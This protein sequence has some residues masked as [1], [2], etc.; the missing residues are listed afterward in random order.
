MKITNY[1]F[2]GLALSL[3]VG[4][5]AIALHQNNVS[6]TRADVSS[7]ATTSFWKR[8]TPFDETENWAALKSTYQNLGADAQALIANQTY[9]SL[10]SSSENY[11]LQR[12]AQ[13]YD[14]IISKYGTDKYEDFL[15]RI[16]LGYIT[17]PSQ[18]MFQI[19]NEGNQTII[20]VSILGAA[21][22]TFGLL[23]LRKKKQA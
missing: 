20:V 12:A 21:V 9:D 3:G 8:V 14:Y 11:N 22:L 10:D 16:S 5:A 7:W 18:G 4:G 23:L 13:R 17:S 6:E 15:C 19:G 2:L 1:L